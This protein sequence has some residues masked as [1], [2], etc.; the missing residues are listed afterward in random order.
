M[1]RVTWLNSCSAVLSDLCSSYSFFC[2]FFYFYTSTYKWR[3]KNL[4]NC[5]FKGDSGGPLQILSS[6]YACTHIQIGIT[7][8]GP[9]GCVRQP[10]VPAVYT[11]VSYYIKWIQGT[12]WPNDQFAYTW[13]YII[14]SKQKI[15]KCIFLF[16][17]K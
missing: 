1:E 12:V 4:T 3:K 2:L 15:S 17:Y 7:S 9:T 5:L 16:N 6:S 10:N 14:H 8:I 11:N 13:N